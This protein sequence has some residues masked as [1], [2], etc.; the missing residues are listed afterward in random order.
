MINRSTDNS[1]NIIE[2]IKTRG[3][4]FK[5]YTQNNQGTGSACNVGIKFFVLV[6]KKQ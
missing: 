2:S 5:M 1:L 4:R 3:H 6:R